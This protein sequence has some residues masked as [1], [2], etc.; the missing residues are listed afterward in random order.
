MQATFNEYEHNELYSLDIKGMQQLTY[1]QH[2][3]KL[4]TKTITATL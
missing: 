4:I 3:N 2:N 1:A